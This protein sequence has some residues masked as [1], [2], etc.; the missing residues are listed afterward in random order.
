[1]K[2]MLISRTPLLDFEDFECTA[3]L[4]SLM[5]AGLTE[6]GKGPSGCG[7][8]GLLLKIVIQCYWLSHETRFIS[9]VHISNMSFDFVA[10]LADES[11]ESFHPNETCPQCVIS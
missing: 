8:E 9:H 7:R 4:A 3:S 6:S 2:T 11:N 5:E 1:M 10:E